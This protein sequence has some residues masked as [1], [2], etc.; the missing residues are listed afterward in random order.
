MVRFWRYTMIILKLVRATNLLLIAATQYA[1][2]FFIL[3]P[4]VQVNNETFEVTTFQ[5]Q[6]SELEF[7]MVVLATVFI[8]AGGYVINDYFDRKTDLINRPGRVIV[9]RLIKRRYAM[10]MHILFTVIGILLGIW[11]SVRTDL[12]VNI[13]VFVGISGLLWFYSTSFKRQLFIGN[14]VIAMLVAF[15]PL[16]ILLFEFPLLIEEYHYYILAAKTNLGFMRSWLLGYAGFAFLITLIREIVKDMEDFEGDYVFG[17][18]SIPIV[19]GNTAAK[20]IV[21]FLSCILLVAIYLVYWFFIHDIIT[22][23][24]LSICITLPVLVV[25]VLLIKAKTQ[26]IYH[27]LSLLLKGIMFSG[28][29][30]CLVVFFIIKNHEI[31]M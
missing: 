15:V 28:L 2:R 12:M 1:L 14:L 26:K 20:A 24:Y 22:L 31:L 3:K 25:I 19:L 5:L 4:S 18:Q 17:R 21:L 7:L 8:A 29:F 27:R 16:I 9:G 11:V 10:A 30:Y 13:V 6:L 23:S